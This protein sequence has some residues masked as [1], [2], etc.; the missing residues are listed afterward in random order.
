[1]FWKRFVFAGEDEDW[2]C[3]S[4]EEDAGDLEVSVD[5]LIDSVPGRKQSSINMLIFG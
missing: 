5:N 3:G 4:D 2:A 1:M